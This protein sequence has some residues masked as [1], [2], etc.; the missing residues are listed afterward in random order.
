LDGQEFQ[1][2]I[3]EFKP[4]LLKCFNVTWVDLLYFSEIV[5]LF[6]D[7]EFVFCDSMGIELLDGLGRALLIQTDPSGFPRNSKMVVMFR[8]NAIS[9]SDL[10]QRKVKDTGYGIAAPHGKW[11]RRLAMPMPINTILEVMLPPRDTGARVFVE[12]WPNF[13]RH[14]R[15]RILIDERATVE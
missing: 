15:G 10:K 6:R 7:E 4:H 11:F 3:G 2:F 12:L 9:R 5:D 14:R 1:G 8:T 13:F